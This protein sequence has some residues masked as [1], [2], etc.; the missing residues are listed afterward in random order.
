MA[1]LAVGLVLP[2]PVEATIGVDDYPGYLKK[3]A[4][5]S[6]VDPWNFYN[7]ECTS[8]VAWRLNHDAGIAFHNW[9]KGHHWGDAAI[10]KQA[11]VSSGVPVD[12][13]P[14]VGAIAWWAMGSAG[15]SRGHVAWVVAVNGSSI[16]VEEYNYLQRGGYD[17]RTISRTASYRPTAYI[18]LGDGA[19]VAMENTARPTVSGTPQVG[20]KLTA[21]PG[22]W[23]PAG[24]TYSYQWYAG[25]AAIT[26]ATN[27]TF[28][29]RPEQLGKQLR[30][31]VISTKTGAQTGTALSAVTAATAPGVLT[32]TAPPTI[33]GTPQ[34]GVQLSATTGTWSPRATYSYR[35]RDTDG[36]IPGATGSTFTPTA[37]Q[38]DQPLRVTVTAT[39]DGYRTARSTSAATTAVRSGTFAEQAPPTITGDAQVDNT[40]VASPGTWSPD[41]PAAYQWLVDGLPVTGATG[42]SYAP[43]ANDVRKQVSVQVSVS[44]PGYEPASATSAA[45]PAVIPG[46]F[47]SSSDPSVTGTP[48]VGVPL[49]AD[50]GGW[51]P[52][53]TLSWQ[54]TADGVPIPGATSSTFTP[55]PAELGKHLTVEVTARRP[56]YLTAVTESPVTAAVLPGANSVTQAPGISGL[57][58]VGRSLSATPGTWAV[59]PTSVDYQWYAGGVAISGAT[60][61]TFTPT[62]AQLDH[63]LTVRAT[64]HADGYQARTAS[65][66]PTSPVLLGRAAF[67]TAPSLTGTALVGHTLT[68]SAGQFTPA[69]A[70][71]GYQWLRGGVAISGATARTYTLQPADV[72][73]SVAVRVTVSAPQWAPTSALARTP[74]RVKSVPQLT[75]RVA[76]HATW[77][78]VS[79]RVVTPGLPDPDGRAKLYEHH[80]LLGTLVVTDGQGYLRLNDLAARTHRVAVHYSGPGPQVAAST[81]VDIAIG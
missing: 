55:S 39:R 56:G 76:G 63:P 61:S 67:T 69:G 8:F 27:P 49:T 17:R 22:T 54:W 77:A 14:K 33:T 79:V 80:R 19:D 15:S 1:T 68:A 3:A 34:V 31:K 32:A 70:T 37:A 57:P 2:A 45:T 38:L 36:P 64:V 78:G 12:G 20:V 4:Q 59:M 46:T 43:T 16:T 35:W 47:R 6:L 10:W 11:A 29:P 21:S 50:P 25:G 48:K 44:L 58:Y 23:T 53:P 26:G 65:S 72:G 41:S 40:L 30:V 66:A 73:R 18:H 74:T 24:G 9:Y 13:T 5:D 62:E 7:R 81:R 52:D 60:S 51:S 28:I 75:V 71:P 42:P